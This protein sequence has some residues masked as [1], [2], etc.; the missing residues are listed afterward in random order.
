MAETIKN[1]W[2]I[3][4][5]NEKIAPYTM[6]NQVLDNKT[7]SSLDILLD[8]LKNSNGQINFQNTYFLSQ[9]M[10]NKESEASALKR[11]LALNGF[12]VIIVDR[13]VTLDGNSLTILSNTF[14]I[15]AHKN[16]TIQNPKSNSIFIFS[17]E[18]AILSNVYIANLILKGN[19]SFG[20]DNNKINC[21]NCK[22]E[23]IS[24]TNYEQYATNNLMFA[25]NL[26]LNSISFTQSYFTL[27]GENLNLQNIQFIS[28]TGVDLTFNNSLINNIIIS[29]TSS[30]VSIKGN[31]NI[32][33]NI[34]FKNN[35]IVPTISGSNNNIQGQ[36]LEQKAKGKNTP[37]FYLSTGSLNNIIIMQLIPSSADPHP[38]GI[39]TKG[40]INNQFYISSPEGAYYN[41]DNLFKDMWVFSDYQTAMPLRVDLEELSENSTGTIQELGAGQYFLNG[42][43]NDE[44][45]PLSSF[46][47]RPADG[48][49]VWLYPISLKNMLPLRANEIYI[50]VSASGVEGDS[51]NIL[52]NEKVS[53]I[54]LT[55]YPNIGLYLNGEFDNEIFSLQQI[56]STKN[57][58]V[59]IGG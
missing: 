21:Q 55:Q 7:G 16:I 20:S 10:K 48:T 53:A 32:F 40:E 30:Y 35:I 28:A 54:S 18:N 13:N 6:L 47:T 26:I 1:Q 3:N 42:T 46:V 22:I 52:P 43:F 11:L 17:L 59:H 12:K 8:N 29:E 23:N 50:S 38:Y 49:E 5:N 36:C 24:I 19:I 25:N 2:L 39:D 58:K 9:E 56:F 14:L 33:Q 27:K 57:N 37:E 15:G 44:F 41:G 51:F 45:L 31:N 4:S 34:I